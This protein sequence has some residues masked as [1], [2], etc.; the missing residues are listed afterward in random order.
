MPS[1]VSH[2]ASTDLRGSKNL[3]DGAREKDGLGAWSHD[4]SNFDDLVQGQITAVLDI[5]HL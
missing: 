3:L 1:R 4:A 5:L 2:E